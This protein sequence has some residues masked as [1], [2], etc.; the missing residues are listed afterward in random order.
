MENNKIESGKNIRE[1]K[2]I[3][4]NEFEGSPYEIANRFN[5]K[6]MEKNAGIVAAKA[7]G[8]LG[9]NFESEMSHFLNRAKLNF[10]PKEKIREKE[11]REEFLDELYKNMLSCV[12]VYRPIVADKKDIEIKEEARKILLNLIFPGEENSGIH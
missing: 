3:K 1:E 10:K 12:D 5:D 4:E 6:F 2:E 11:E 8:I 9:H 7:W